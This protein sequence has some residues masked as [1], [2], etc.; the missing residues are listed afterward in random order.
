MLVLSR[1]PGQPVILADSAGNVFGNI[2]ARSARNQVARVTVE[3]L[4][5]YAVVLPASLQPE[6]VVAP[7]KEGVLNASGMLTYEMQL[8]TGRIL[9]VVFQDTTNDRKVTIVVYLLEVF[10]K[11]IKLGFEAPRDVQIYRL[12]VWNKRQQAATSAEAAPGLAAS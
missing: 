9:H 5:G 1:Y 2:S 3:L 11:V 12:E 8:S 7:A 6:S 4:P 10:N